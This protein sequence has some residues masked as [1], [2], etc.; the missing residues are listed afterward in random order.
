M[1]RLI[2]L[3]G[4]AVA[5]LSFAG[6]AQQQPFR[7]GVDVVTLDVSVIQGNRPVAGLTSADF[8]VTDNG[9]RQSVDAVLADALPLDLT[10]AV[11][12]SGSVENMK[13]EVTQQVRAAAGL[14]K[15]QDR[16]R[17]LAFSWVARDVFGLQP[18]SADLQIASLFTGGNT[19]LNDAVA[20][21]LMRVRPAGRGEIAVLF[22]DGVDNTSSVSLPMLKELARRSD[23]PLFIY[24]VR[25]GVDVVMDATFGRVDYVPFA[26]LAE[27]T[28][29]RLESLMAGNHIVAGLTRVL[30]DYRRSY[31][32]R[33]S[34]TGVARP[35]WHDLKV[36]I[37][38]PGEFAVRAR[39]GYFGG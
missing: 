19:S 11:D 38:K 13:E 9:V 16:I 14:L 26:D 25:S 35:G 1:T 7:A 27:T 8:L 34:A 29:G 20:A 18:P 31:T 33:Y 15:P 32:L 23:V 36:T 30:D 10:L 6:L 4:V 22:T 37:N 24:M 5:S 21:T 2:A 12:T 17:L 28:G 39:K 3:A